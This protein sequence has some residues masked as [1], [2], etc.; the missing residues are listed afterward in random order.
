MRKEIQMHREILGLTD[1]KQKVDHINGNRLDNR[2][3]NLRVVT[4]S[5]NHMN[6]V[7]GPGTSKYKGVS[8]C[9]KN[10]WRVFIGK[11]YKKYRYGPFTDEVEA[12]LF[13]DMKA[14]ELF[15]QYARPNFLVYGLGF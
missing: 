1:P 7:K 5:Q 12:A 11:D 14:L 6:R 2:R 15:G 4:D 9:G 8:R 13:Y 3:E 10:R